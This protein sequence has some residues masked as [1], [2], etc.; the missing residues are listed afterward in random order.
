[1]C[2]PDL[3]VPSHWKHL[4]F[5]G[6]TNF[7]KKYCRVAMRFTNI[8]NQI[9]VKVNNTFITWY[10]IIS[11]SV[12]ASPH[13]T[14]SLCSAS[15]LHSARHTTPGR[16]FSS[17]LRSASLYIQRRVAAPLSRSTS[18]FYAHTTSSS[19]F[20]F[21]IVL[22]KFS[23]HGMHL[24]LHRCVIFL[25]N[26]YYTDHDMVDTTSKGSAFKN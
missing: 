25:Q 23:S 4:F 11:L 17:M 10:V 21:A 22:L 14:P 9:N 7:D 5:K 15:M 2:C 26:V 13:T 24:A 16:R 1:M 6:C 3:S 20:F 12:P 18:M 8:S 19:T